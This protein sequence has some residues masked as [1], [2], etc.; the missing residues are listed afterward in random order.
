MNARLVHYKKG[1]SIFSDM[2]PWAHTLLFLGNPCHRVDGR[3]VWRKTWGNQRK[4][5]KWR[6]RA[7]TGRNGTAGWQTT[8][9]TATKN[10]KW[11]ADIRKYC[12]DRPIEEVIKSQWMTDNNV[13]MLASHLIC[14]R[15]CSHCNSCAGTVPICRISCVC[16]CAMSAIKLDLISEN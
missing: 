3:I 13:W 12:Q 14:L 11:I 9:L 4:K 5:E 16:E 6:E 15:P 2:G 10:K 8:G 1:P 7:N